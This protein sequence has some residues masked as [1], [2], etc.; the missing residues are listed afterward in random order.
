MQFAK[1]AID[2]DQYLTQLV[3]L[4]VDVDIARATVALAVARRGAEKQPP[5]PAKI[6]TKALTELRGK[7]DD[8]LETFA[9]KDQTTATLQAV[10]ERLGLIEEVLN[11]LI[12]DAEEQRAAAQAEEIAE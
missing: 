3:A 8:A 4:G 7:V 6:D 11:A 1:A 9:D 10:L 2:A 5:A 12:A